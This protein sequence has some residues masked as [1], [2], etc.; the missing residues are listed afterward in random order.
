MSFLFTTAEAAV[1]STNST[2]NS[3][4][5]KISANIITPIVE[6]LFVFAM[7]IFIWGIVG[8]IMGGEDPERRKQGQS[9][10]L[11]GVVGMA[12]MVSVYG[13][14]RFVFSS[15]GQSAPF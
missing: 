4:V 11:W 9:H 2:V 12:I 13:I 7:L 6:F 15:V 8:Y 5:S 10:I 1:S 3:I 14:V